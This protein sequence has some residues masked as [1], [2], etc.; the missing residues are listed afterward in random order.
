MVF[1]LT[2]SPSENGPCGICE[3]PFP[4]SVVFLESQSLDFRKRNYA[5]EMGLVWPWDGATQFASQTLEDD[6]CKP[7]NEAGA[8][9]DTVRIA[10]VRLRG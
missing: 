8:W 2:T 7:S 6:H 1:P 5:V 10:S 4:K 9:Q 3:K